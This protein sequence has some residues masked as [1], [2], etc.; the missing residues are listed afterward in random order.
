MAVGGAF[1]RI[2]QT[3]LRAIQLC[4]AIVACGIFA[5]F[6][7]I[8]ADH[9]FPIATYVR[10]VTGMSGAAIIY[11]AFAVLLTLCFAGVAFLSFIAVVLDILFAGCFA[12]IAYYTRGGAG[13]C[14]GNV[15]TPLGSGPSDSQ[16]QGYGSNGFGTG[17]GKNATYR[18]SLRRACKL[19][20]AVFAV[21]IV[22]M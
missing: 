12:A 9:K 16:A 2:V 7:A 19:E 4:C 6:L 13:S 3:L 22:A 21:S 11:T 18:P 5:Y 14:S 20:T 10:A 17:S 8:L 1:L 15:N